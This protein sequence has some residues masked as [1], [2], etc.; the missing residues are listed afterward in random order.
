M[1]NLKIS[2]L[3]FL[4]LLC[5]PFGNIYAKHI[6][7]GEMYYECL[8]FTDGDPNSGSRTYRFYMRLYRDQE[9]G[10]LF[11]SAP[12]STASATVTIYRGNDRFAIPTQILISPST[13]SV[14]IETGNNCF[15]SPSFL[16]IE[17]GLYTFEDLDIPISN[18][19][20]YIVYQRCCRTPALSNINDPGSSG[21]TY[22]IEL[23]PEA[24][25]TCN[26][27]PQFQA[28]EGFYLCTGEPFT[29]DHSAT[30]VDG[31]RL[32]YSFCEP[33]LGG[34]S[35]NVDPFSSN[36]IAPNPDLGP[37]YE[38]VDFIQPTYSTNQPVGPTSNFNIDP[39]TG[40]I[41]GTPMIS[42]QFVVGVCVREFDA[43]NQLLSEVRRDF[44]FQASNCEKN[45]EINI[46]SDFVDNNGIPTVNA[47]GV[48][49][50]TLQ[51]NS[52]QSDEV[53]SFFWEFEIN[54]Q[55]QTF[56]DFNPL[57]DFDQPGTYSGRFV[58]SST[59]GCVDTGEV[60]VQVIAAAQAGFEVDSD[61]CQDEL[62]VFN[63]TT[64]V[65]QNVS[66][67]YMWDFG[68]G[69]TSSD[70]STSY[71]Y[72]TP[73]TR[74][75]QLLVISND[76]CRDSLSQ[77]I[78]YFPI[79]R[80][81]SLSGILEQGCLPQQ[82]DFS[83]NLS[84]FNEQYT[85]NWDFGD[86]AQASGRNATHT[87][88]TAG[89]FA[90]MLS[91][92]TP[93]GCILDSMLAVIPV[94]PSPVADFNFSPTDPSSL[95]P[96]VNFNDLSQNANQW[97]WDFAGLGSSSEQNPSFTFPDSA[98]TYP[99]ELIVTH[100]NGC[101]D[102]LSRSVQLSSIDDFYVPNAFSPNND[103]INDEFK[104]FGPLSGKQN[105]ELTI[106]SRWGDRIFLTTDPEEGWNG[107]L[108]NTGE[109]LPQGVY[110][111]YLTF[112]NSDGKQ[113]SLKGLLNLLK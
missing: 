52:T 64:T 46:P 71:T 82:A 38:S 33:L 1:G 65:P 40:I 24:Q 86:G 23:T 3:Y 79:L 41:T 83:A 100:P 13:R 78:D 113:I 70:V 31:H 6:V 17:E 42:G 43:N 97:S 34:G 75:V 69:S 50:V 106:F 16:Q 44:Q 90:P 94:E 12:G 87:Y 67:D 104:G 4:V 112:K 80:P 20:Y 15:V 109:F 25:Q 68:D 49:G 76:F 85:I 91:I 66:V 47:C 72:N 62:I 27:S 22:F 60:N 110:V 92:S 88:T 95:N 36:G 14:D 105:F 103:G 48:S 57:I 101:T 89:D 51:N 98:G 18:E 21:A 37:P 55:T 29:L 84:L 81:L 11:D 59:R 56:T 45:I 10:E 111:Y 54:G 35:D 73:G 9:G 39:N 28:F 107:R 63:N 26:N 96:L 19:S 5:L 58:L 74:E 53:D 77:T 30:D 93:G 61:L 102:R 7:G 8:G 2:L 108:N 99:V 32:E